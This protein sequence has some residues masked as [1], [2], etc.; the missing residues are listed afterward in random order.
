MAILHKSL[1]YYTRRFLSIPGAASFDAVSCKN[2]SDAIT[3]NF[4]DIGRESTVKVVLDVDRDPENNDSSVLCYV[5]INS[6]DECLLSL[7]MNS[8]IAIEDC[9]SALLGK[10]CGNR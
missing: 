8:S 4:P 9:D 1:C 5:G 10:P 7:A 3:L 2:A 6:C